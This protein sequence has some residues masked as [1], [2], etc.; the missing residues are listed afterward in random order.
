MFWDLRE[1]F[2]FNLYHGGVEGARL[3]T[4]LPQ[5][6]RVRHSIFHSTPTSSSVSLNTGK[7]KI[8]GLH[9]FIECLVRELDLFKI[10]L[11]ITCFVI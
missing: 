10:T 9:I 8:K 3:E 7:K 2:I 5:F 1:P 6:D 11:V 4:M